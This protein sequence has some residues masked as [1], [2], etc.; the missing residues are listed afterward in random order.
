MVVANRDESKSRNTSSVYFKVALNSIYHMYRA[1]TKVYTQNS[2][3][4]S[5]HLIIS[6][7][8]SVRAIA[9]PICS[10]QIMLEGLI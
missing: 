4:F 3:I 8:I 7:K 5:C 2:N 6:G 1:N 10:S 9:R